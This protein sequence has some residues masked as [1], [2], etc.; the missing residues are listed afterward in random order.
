[1]IILRAHKQPQDAYCNALRLIW[2]RKRLS[3]EVKVGFPKYQFEIHWRGKMCRTNLQNTRPRR[4][5]RFL[6]LYSWPQTQLFVSNNL[7]PLQKREKKKTCCQSMFYCLVWESNLLFFGFTHDHNKTVLVKQKLTLCNQVRRTEGI[8][9]AKT[10]SL[11][12]ITLPALISWPN[13]RFTASIKYWHSLFMC[14][15]FG[16]QV[17]RP[18]PVSNTGLWGHDSGCWG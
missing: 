2:H 13:K 8:K 10:S 17:P 15:V 1:M 12:A 16:W 14:C 4:K 11:P 18:G 3:L 7:F 9:Q 5:K 6:D